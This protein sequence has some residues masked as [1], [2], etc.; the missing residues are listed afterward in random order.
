MLF[1]C[2]FLISPTYSTGRVLY[3]KQTKRRTKVTL[4]TFSLLGDMSGRLLL[5]GRLPIRYV[6]HSTKPVKFC[7]GDAFAALTNRIRNA[8]IL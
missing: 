4:L 6:L 7:M 1:L 3:V 5:V 2:Y 8:K